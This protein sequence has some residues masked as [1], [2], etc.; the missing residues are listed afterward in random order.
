MLRSCLGDNMTF[1]I[2]FTYAGVAGNGSPSIGKAM[3]GDDYAD[4]AAT[5][6]WAQSDDS[7]N[8]AAGDWTID[9]ADTVLRQLTFSESVDRTYS[10]NPFLGIQ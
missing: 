9:P 2:P 7:N 5:A 8:L 4:D 6:W 1:D 3:D 10:F